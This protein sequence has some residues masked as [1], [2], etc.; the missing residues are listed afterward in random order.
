MQR[1]WIANIF[2]RFS[3]DEILFHQPISPAMSSPSQALL[4]AI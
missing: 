4:L 3:F 2:F 1:Q